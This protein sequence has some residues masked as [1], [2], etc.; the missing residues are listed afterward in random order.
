M[1]IYVEIGIAD[2][3]KINVGNKCSFISHNMLLCFVL[4]YRLSVNSQATIATILTHY[5]S[6]NL[7]QLWHY[8]AF[9]LRFYKLNHQMPT[10][11]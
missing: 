10:C 6:F 8:I 9:D 4:E 5:F 3:M 1:S 2:Q 11:K 7:C